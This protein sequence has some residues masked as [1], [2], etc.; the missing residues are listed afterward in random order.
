MDLQEY[1]SKKEAERAKAR[2][3]RN[4]DNVDFRE[5]IVE[6]YTESSYRDIWMTV[7]EDDADMRQ[8]FIFAK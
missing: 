2:L 7:F 3:S 1:N 5:Q 6:T 4:Y 8:R